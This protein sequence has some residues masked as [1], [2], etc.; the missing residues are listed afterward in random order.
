[1]PSPEPTPKQGPNG[2]LVP[3]MQ[4]ASLSTAPGSH[5]VQSLM[6]GA[7]ALNGQERYSVA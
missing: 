7:R 1:M 4:T 5:F 6:P 2:A 3:N